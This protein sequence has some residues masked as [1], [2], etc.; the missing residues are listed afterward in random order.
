VKEKNASIGFF[1]HDHLPDISIAE[2]SGILSPKQSV[3]FTLP[4]KSQDNWSVGL[5][6]EAWDCLP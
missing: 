2:T 1:I 5:S 3:P 4:I 6:L